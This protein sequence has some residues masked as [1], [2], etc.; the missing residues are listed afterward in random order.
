MT[1]YEDLTCEQIDAL[2]RMHVRKRA[3]SQQNIMQASAL[4]EA[5]QRCILAANAKIEA[6][7]DQR[8]AISHG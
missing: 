5:E 4:I 3:A 6:L 7:L 2:L 8:T 1:R